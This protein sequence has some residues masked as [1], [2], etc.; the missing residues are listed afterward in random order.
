M[1]TFAGSF[2]RWS[3]SLQRF[4]TEAEHSSRS[5]LGSRGA[6]RRAPTT[7]A[8]GGRVGMIGGE[9]GWAS[10]GRVGMIGGELGWANMGASELSRG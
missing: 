9:L 10:G 7:G 2:H 4:P 3:S 1:H 5:P 6:S 8:S